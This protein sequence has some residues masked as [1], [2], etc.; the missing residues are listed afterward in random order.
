M[1]ENKLSDEDREF[2]Q[3]AQE[4]AEQRRRELHKQL[5]S[6]HSRATG[7]IDQWIQELNDLSGLTDG[8]IEADV[9][10]AMRLSV[11]NTLEATQDATPE[12][13]RA[14]WMA[15]GCHYWVQRGLV[16]ALEDE[17]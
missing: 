7:T 4:R 9:W 11:L 14:L 8:S 10:D 1:S 17:A 16:V 15:I 3:Q 5:R 13:A 12:R 2:L 6:F